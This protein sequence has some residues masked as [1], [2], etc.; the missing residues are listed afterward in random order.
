MFGIH[1]A[2]GSIH[3]EAVHA[4]LEERDQNLLAE[5]VLN[6]NLEITRDAVLETVARMRLAEN[7]LRRAQLK[8]RVKELERAGKG[9]EA[10]RAM[11][12]LSALEKARP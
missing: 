5:A 3:F 4:R 7:E 11:E 12:E 1:D 6:R 10:L 2:G 9:P 8:A